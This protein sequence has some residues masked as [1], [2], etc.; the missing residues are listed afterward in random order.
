MSAFVA[1]ACELRG[2]KFQ[3]K[4]RGMQVVIEMNRQFVT[5]SKAPILSN[6]EQT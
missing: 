5:P 3:G 1:E 2:K 6:R 4:I